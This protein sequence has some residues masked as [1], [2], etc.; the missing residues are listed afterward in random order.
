[1]TK[2]QLVE[3]IQRAEAKL[4]KKLQDATELYGEAD[5][6]TQRR[7]SEWSSVYELSEALGIEAMPVTQLKAEGLLPKFID[8]NV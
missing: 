5:P 4:W 7:R 3:G 6:I 2:K 1:M 8:T